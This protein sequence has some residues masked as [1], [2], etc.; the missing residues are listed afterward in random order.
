MTTVKYDGRK[1]RMGGQDWVLAPLNLRQIRTTLKDA[2]GDLQGADTEKRL[3]AFV[4]IIHGSLSRNYPDITMEQVEEMLD[5]G[6]I[7]AVVEAVMNTS[8]LVRTASGGTASE[9]PS[10]GTT[11]TGTL[12]QPS[13]AGLGS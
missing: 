1:V 13:P 6:N 9:D 2:I 5:T 12:S 10:P 3:T 4:N 8:G 7:G 11:F